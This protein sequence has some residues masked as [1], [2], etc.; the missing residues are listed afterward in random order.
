MKL[1]FFHTN[2]PLPRAPDGL[3]KL[4]AVRLGVITVIAAMLAAVLV[5]LY[6]DFYQTI[7]QAKAVIVLKQEVALENI[8][9]TLYNSVSAIHEYKIA[10]RTS[11]IIADP[12][13]TV[14]QTPSPLTGD[15]PA[16]EAGGGGEGQH[17]AE[18]PQTP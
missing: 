12:F 18:E 1:P 2:K 3:D 16:G 15:P 6:R 13:N 9:L 14:P 17:Q 8:N 4:H 11:G 10:P 7:I 5:F